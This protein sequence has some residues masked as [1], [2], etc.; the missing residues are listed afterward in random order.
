[1]DGT[2][3][4]VLYFAWMRQRV[5]L[6]S[7]RIVVPPEVATLGDLV[8]W[9]AAQDAGHASAFENPRLVRVALNQEFAPL[10]ARFAAGDEVAFFPP[11]TGG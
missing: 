10:D 9:L 7:E 1:M 3:L 8:S 11:V 5:G 4:D 6:A 2:T